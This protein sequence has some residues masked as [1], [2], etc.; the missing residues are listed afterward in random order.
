MTD[1]FL[2]SDAVLRLSTRTLILRAVPNPVGSPTTFTEGC[3]Q[4]AR[5]TLALHQKC[6]AIVERSKASL[7]MFSTYM[8]WYVPTPNSGV[9]LT[10]DQDDP[11]RPL[12]P[13]HCLVLP[14]HRDQG[15]SGS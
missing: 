13:L 12:C 1:Y 11:F 6:M 3:I 2:L 4:A 9:I 8:N 15:P 5:E 10:S 14:S 7:L